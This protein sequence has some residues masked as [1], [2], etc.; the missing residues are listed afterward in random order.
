MAFTGVY[1]AFPL[2]PSDFGLFKVCEME[3]HVARNTNEDWVRGF[4]Q[5]VESTP[6]AVRNWDVTSNTSVD[7]FTSADKS[8]YLDRITPFFVE[9]ED[10]RSTMGVLGEDRFARIIRQLEAATQKAV[11][12]E[13]WE[14]DIAQAESLNNPF[15]RGSTATVLNGGNA[16]SAKRAIA[17]LEHYIGDTSAVGEQGFIHLTRDIAAILSSN[18]QMLF[19]NKE[20]DHHQTLGGTPVIIG[21]GYTGNGPLSE[22]E[23][24]DA[25]DFSKWMYATGTLRVYLGKAEVVNENLAQGYN[26]SG[27]KNDI[28]IKATRPVVAY[29][30]TSIHLAVKVDLSL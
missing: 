3:T 7:I 25:T 21:S 19:H 14:G 2:Q 20:K 29:F 12:Y 17:L 9:V 27:N 10:Y 15:L 24:G 6:T 4:S 23:N 13:L 11:E 26:V 22:E 30:D 8:T 28:K 18:S 5:I 16:L 1:E